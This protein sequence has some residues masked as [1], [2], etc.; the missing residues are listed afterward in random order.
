VLLHDLPWV[1]DAYLTETHFHSGIWCHAA[2]QLGP[3]Q[4][5][6]G[7]M[8]DHLVTQDRRMRPM[9]PTSPGCQ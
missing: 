9:A 1:P 7:M 6:T 2:V 4:A 3:M 5:L 8:A